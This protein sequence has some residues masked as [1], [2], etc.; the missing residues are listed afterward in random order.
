MRVFTSAPPAKS[1]VLPR[2][3]FHRRT[4]RGF[5]L[6]ELLVAIAISVIIVLA[7]AA[8][9]SGALKSSTTN[10]NSLLALSAAN[11]AL[12]LIANDLKSVATSGETA[13]TGPAPAGG[14]FPT[15]PYE[16][17]QARPDGSPVTTP[18]TK[19]NGTTP[20]LLMMNTISAQDSISYPNDPGM[21]PRAV[22]YQI[23]FQDPINPSNNNTSAKVYGLYRTVEPSSTTFVNFLGTNDLYGTASSS[24]WYSILSGSS[25]PASSSFIVGN[26][27]DFQLVFY[28]CPSILGGAA[29]GPMLTTPIKIY[30]TADSASVTT[31]PN[32]HMPIHLTNM[33]TY[34]LASTGSTTLPSSLY[35]A[36]LQSGL[37]TANSGS[38]GSITAHGPVQFVDVTI[39]VL[40]NNGAVE[41]G[42]GV[43]SLATAKARYGHSL[44][45]RIAIPEPF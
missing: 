38:S 6:V 30:S 10:N 21:Q 17:L 42:N 36:S 29:T 24:Q 14:P 19:L 22:C 32:Y 43:I 26:V 4:R 23:A 5:T 27:V 20:A 3:E 18:D 16:F 11:A 37:D 2:V 31:S 35:T 9:T 12:D 7:L 34:I 1:F 15:T 44:T 8:V 28:A 45:R 39:T 41:L 25:F 13:L 33:G 40:D